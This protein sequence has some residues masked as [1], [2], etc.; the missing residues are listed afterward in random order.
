MAVTQRIG[1]DGVIL[2]VRDFDEAHRIVEVLTSDHGRVSLLAR[3]ARASRRR[4]AGALDLFTSLRMQVAMGRSLWTLESA[5]I[6]APRVGIR[7]RLELIERASMMCDCARALT[8]EQQATPAAYAALIAGLDA[9]DAGREVEAAAVYP[10]LLI[11]AGI[12]PQAGSCATCGVLL[13]ARGA[14][15]TRLGGLVCG[16][17]VQGQASLSD[18][19]LTAWRSGACRDAAAAR[20][21]EAAAVAW[22]ESH[23]GRALRS[24]LV[25]EHAESPSFAKLSSRAS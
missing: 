17:C 9:L 16:G 19:A 5:D 1:L 12:A 7:R 3:G 6:R 10:L 13:P 18:E 24:R 25:R 2:H 22:V 15:D 23:I 11:A 8:S 21:I 14:F 20:E 4:F